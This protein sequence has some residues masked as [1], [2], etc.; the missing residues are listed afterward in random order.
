MLLALGASVLWAGRGPWLQEGRR[1]AQFARRAPRSQPPPRSGAARRARARRSCCRRRRPTAHEAHP[2]TLHPA[3]RLPSP[4]SHPA[5]WQP[6]HPGDGPGVHQP[7]Q[8]GGRQEAH[9]AAGHDPGLHPAAH[10]GGQRR[11]HLRRCWGGRAMP[12]GSGAPAGAPTGH[13][14]Y[15][16]GSGSATGRTPALACSTPPLTPGPAGP[17]RPAVVALSKDTSTDADGVMTVKGDPSKLVQTATYTGVADAQ[18]CGRARQDARPPGARAC[19]RVSASRARAR[20]S[21]PRLVV[22]PRAGRRCPRAL[23]LGA[24]PDLPTPPPPS[25]APPP[26]PRT[27]APLQ[28]LL[29]LDPANATDVKQLTV[30][31]PTGFRFFQVKWAGRVGGAVSNS[32]SVH[33]WRAATAA[34]VVWWA[35][36]LG[37]KASAAGP[38]GRQRAGGAARSPA[39]PCG[40]AARR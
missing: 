8:G 31:T 18:V 3:S 26:P 22:L 11:P 24:D 9:D 30:Y 32:R 27:P 5:R 13:R 2:C 34:W 16:Y 10:A 23:P 7:A 29:W 14:A 4:V 15:M 19:A 35:R 33:G 38:G 17:R 12:G 36:T 28:A 40:P 21:H 6:V 20:H 37:G 25:P 1:A 39:A